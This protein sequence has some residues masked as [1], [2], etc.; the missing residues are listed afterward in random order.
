MAVG[1]ANAYR[2]FIVSSFFW[3]LISAVRYRRQ[4]TS[5]RGPDV[6]LV[7]LSRWQLVA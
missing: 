5:R 6:K 2:R 7:G 1:L 3:L 4:D